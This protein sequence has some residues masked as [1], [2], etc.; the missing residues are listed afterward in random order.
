MLLWLLEKSFKY[1]P[2]YLRIIG[3][4]FSVIERLLLIKLDKITKQS[5]VSC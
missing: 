2:A 4:E 1:E 3:K 5:F